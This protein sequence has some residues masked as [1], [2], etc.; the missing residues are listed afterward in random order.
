MAT[1]SSV[2]SVT[3]EFRFRCGIHLPPQAN[4]TSITQSFRANQTCRS[5]Q[6]LTFLLA[7]PKHNAESLADSWAN[8]TSWTHGQH[9]RSLRKL[10]A[11][12]LTT[13]S[14][15]TTSSRWMFAH[16]LTTSFV[17]GCL[18]PPFVRTSSTT[19]HHGRTLRCRDGFLIQTAKR[20]RSQ[21]ATS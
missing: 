8:Q 2:V 19:L 11:V 15:L 10:R 12:G 13:R 16:K 14:C 5:T 21:R 4:P 20:C 3:S 9:R 7:L 18:P 6:V 17:R 1:G